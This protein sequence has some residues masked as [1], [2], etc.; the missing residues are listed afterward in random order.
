MNKRILSSFY[1]DIIKY[2]K[3]KNIKK[4]DINSV[5]MFSDISGFTE[6]SEK[7]MKDQISGSEKIRDII[8]EH[9]NDYINT[10]YENDGDL[11]QFSGDAILSIHKDIKSA[12][13]TANTIIDTTKK[14]GI[15]RVKCGIGCGNINIDIFNEDYTLYLFHGEGILKAMKAEKGCKPMEIN[16]NCDTEI[17]I[18]IP[19]YAIELY[20]PS[21][22]MSIIE[23]N[24][25][26]Y[27][28]FSFI[29]SS[30]IL[31]DHKNIDTLNRILSVT[32]DYIHINK[33]E[34]YPEGIRIFAVCGVPI[35]VKN[36]QLLMTSYILSLPQ[37]K[38]KVGITSG[39]VFNGFVGNKR[40]YEFNI[41]GKAI[42]RTA[43]I[44]SLAKNEVLCDR[45]FLISVPDISFKRKGEFNLKG[46]GKTKLFSI[47]EIYQKLPLPQILWKSDH[48]IE[49][50]NKLI[51]NQNKIVIT[52]ELGSGR[53]S[54]VSSVM[55]DKDHRY[56]KFYTYNIEGT[57]ALSQILNI[58]EPD[59]TDDFKQR[60]KEK[61]ANIKEK[62][63]I[64]DNVEN[65][66]TVSKEILYSIELPL[67]KIIIIDIG[68]KG[69]LNIPPKTMEDLKEIIKIRTGIYPSVKFLKMIYKLTNGNLS[70]MFNITQS[71]IKKNALY[72]NDRE[73]WDM[74]TDK[75]G[76]TPETATLSSL[77]LSTLS[78][79][80][81]NIIKVASISQGPFTKEF[82]SYM[83]NKDVS[84][85]IIEIMNAGIF[86]SIENK[87]IFSN[88][89]IKEAIYDSLL[90]KEK[91]RLH[92]KAYQFF[93]MKKQYGMAGLHAYHCGMK[94][95]AFNLLKKEIFTDLYNNTDTRFF[96]PYLLLSSPKNR[97]KEISIVATLLISLTGQYGK[98]IRII[99]NL[100]LPNS[101]KNVLKAIIFMKR[102]N[103]SM[104]QKLLIKNMK[105]IKDPV[106]RII[107]YDILSYAL[108]LER[109]KES[110]K[111][112]D[113][114]LKEIK[115]RNLELFILASLHLPRTYWEMREKNKCIEVYN[116]LKKRYK[117]K[118]LI[119]QVKGIEM[120]VLM[121]KS[122]TMNIDEFIK[123]FRKYVKFMEQ[124]NMK[125][126][127]LSSYANLG[128]YLYKK[129]EFK[130]S[131]KYIKEAIKMAEELE[132]NYS[133]IISMNNL[134]LLYIDTGRNEEAKKLL[135]KIIEKSIKMGETQTLENAYGN[136]GVIYHT[137]E[138][139]EKAYNYYEK[140]LEI[141]YKNDFS[142]SRFL[143]II[144]LALLGVDTGEFENV[145]YYLDMARE[146]IKKNKM[147][148]RWID[149]EQIA[150]NCYFLQGKYKESVKIL[151]KVIKEAKKRGEMDIY[152]ESLSYYAGSLYAIGNKEKAKKIFDKIEAFAQKNNN[153]YL[154]DTVLKQI[155]KYINYKE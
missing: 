36:P 154:T 72:I 52:G 101:Y 116:I 24:N 109:K 96:A 131:E 40:R 48:M 82:L 123:K 28:K 50:L 4:M 136:L 58:E 11:L 151:D 55:S 94:K 23:D 110:I 84:H 102:G 111:F 142:E 61:L 138:N 92:K 139:Y 132:K 64:F 79:H 70:L 137:E 53:T 17:N 148:H 114:V 144:N 6:L 5:V 21:Q 87:Y 8:N 12:V 121:V 152:Y 65:A 118:K 147:H 46:I 103:A 126:K 20:P 97:L 56:F 59:N 9:F 37:N 66:D 146:E 133:E 63:I 18:N 42:N 153:V 143:W 135:E 51:N 91:N 125:I 88:E 47:E 22:I 124:H 54:L 115:E 106:F 3:Q 10:I 38:I 13:K 43:R 119:K 45:Q 68:T 71:L 30:F 85:H 117:E 75:I 112:A 19:H 107:G 93:I 99:D 16:R 127:L 104:S 25:L 141:S 78:A 26:N 128:F 89:I 57:P 62:F 86:K 39:Y 44:A 33:I 129:G 140:A 100:P 95:T 120:S 32:P 29:T 145:E 49:K 7:Y 67:K 77:I 27:G 76:I 105:Y 155:K 34:Q 69:D 134:A 108:S 35:P 98:G 14:K 150:G 2:M 41:M 90:T 74:A 149:V 83:T 122:D 130:K 73:E 1:P 81:E 60:V 31:L 113:I 80:M 15:V